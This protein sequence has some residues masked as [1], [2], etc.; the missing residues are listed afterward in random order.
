[1]AL[2]S[3]KTLAAISLSIFSTQA[4]TFLPAPPADPNKGILYLDSFD[5]QILNG[6]HNGKFHWYGEKGNSQLTFRY[7][8]EDHA[9]D[10]GS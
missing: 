5:I 9:I 4:A 1:M 7:P 8:D 2:F 6:S 3:W 10:F